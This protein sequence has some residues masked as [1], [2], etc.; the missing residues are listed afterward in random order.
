MRQVGV[1]QGKNND[2]DAGGRGGRISPD[3]ISEY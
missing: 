1:G 3:G 2:A